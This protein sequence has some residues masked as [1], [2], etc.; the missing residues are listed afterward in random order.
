M[1]R[2]LPPIARAAAKAGGFDALIA[3]I[4]GDTLSP[5]LVRLV[6]PYLHDLWLRPDQAIPPHDWRLL[7]LRAGR[8]WGKSYTAAAYFIGE[9]MSGRAR[10][11]TALMGANEQRVRELQADVLIALSPPW[12][13]PVWER[14]GLTWPNG[15]RTEV[16]TPGA[17]EIARG[18]NYS[19]CW[20]TEIVAWPASQSM[21][22]YE[23]ITTA[24]R[25]DR[26][27]VIVDTTSKGPNTVIAHINKLHEIDPVRYPKINGTMFDNPLFD[28]AYLESEVQKYGK[29]SRRY[30]EEVEGLDFGEAA[31][32]LWTLEAINATRVLIAPSPMDQVIV[33]LDPSGSARSDA[34][35]TGIIVCGRKGKD[36]YVLHD[37]S[38]RV[39]PGDWAKRVLDAAQACGATGVIVE[40]S[41]SGNQ[42]PTIIKAEART[43]SILVTDVGRRDPFPPRRNGVLYCKTVIAREDKYS[44]AVGPAGETAAGRLH[45]VGDLPELEAEMVGYT[46]EGKGAS[47]GRYDALVHCVNELAGLTGDAPAADQ[48]GDYRA[49]ANATRKMGVA[50]A[51]ALGARRVGM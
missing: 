39:E 47:P 6:L 33:S 15:V 34:D 46:P 21:A 28:E 4:A 13:R 8:G 30:Q 50:I 41:G 43:R 44:R 9:I 25:R 11:K 26:A 3:K 48:R 5:D 16:F 32:A 36:V 31:G 2:N 27:Q 37:L 14:D 20:L 38:G 51:A 42:P 12:F 23:A 10:G 7:A 19:L 24:T 22:A 17:A 18:G 35:I 40:T 45:I 49:A 29:G 1:K